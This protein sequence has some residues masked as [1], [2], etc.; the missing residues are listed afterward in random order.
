M[1]LIKSSLK[2]ACF[3]ALFVLCGNLFR[4]LLVD[5]TDSYTR[6]MMHEF[7][8]QK[9]IDI[10]FVGSSHCYG[11]LDPEVTDEIFGMNT[12][13]AGSSLQALDASYALIR[14]AADLYD[15]K[16][17]YLEMYYLMM[18]N[19]DYRDRED[20]TG[21]YIVSD[22]MRPSLNKARFLLGAGPSKY[23]VNSFIPARRYWEKLLHPA[24]VF[25]LLKEKA[26]DAYRNYG[27]VGAYK[28]KGFIANQGTIP[29]GLLLDT[30]GFDRVD[31]GKKSDDWTRT[32]REII[33]FCEKKGIRL[34]LFSAPMTLFQTV[35]LGNYDEYIETVREL[36]SGTGIEYADFNLCREAYFDQS[37]DM[38]VD[39]GHMNETG[40]K[41]FS[42]VFA[43]HFTGGIGKPELFYDSMA[44]KTAA[45]GP[46]ILGVSFLDSGDG[47]RKMKIVST[48]PENTAYEVRLIG[49]DGS[50]KIVKDNS[51]DLFF[52]LP[53]D[54][55]GTMQILASGQT[56]EIEV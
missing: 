37:A 18:G 42:R 48:M 31:A 45:A 12:F 5:D 7:Y 32:L 55:H 13:N 3:I 23:Y 6:L 27:P 54:A 1:H 47:M 53:Q 36:L 29:N 43:D 15:V 21:T 51:V 56:A 19:D 38:F 26:S 33:R 52:E 24:E 16:Q 49:A 40:A 28:A 17:V 9:N 50:E 20:M 34:T 14:E 22:Y 4:Y 44:E 25:S 46:R 8:G 35:G 41:A 2:A 11:S 39:A 30:A 10:L